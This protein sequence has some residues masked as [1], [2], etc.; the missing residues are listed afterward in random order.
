MS[1][2]ISDIVEIVSQQLG[3]F[4]I[5]ADGVSKF[6]AEDSEK[7]LGSPS[8]VHSVKY[9]IKDIEHLR[10]KISR[11]QAEGRLIS[12]ANVFQ[13]ITDI[14]GIRVLHLHLEQL[15]IIHAAILK[16]DWVLAETPK[17]Y[18][19]D[20]ETVTF[21]QSL[22]LDTH[23]KPSQYTSVHYVVKPNAASPLSCEIQV[24][25]LFEEIWGEVDHILNYPTPTTN[26]AS[27]EQLKVLAKVV[28]AG[29]RLVDSLFRTHTT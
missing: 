10:E 23:L 14:A 13:E 1:Q 6:F 27:A 3:E 9:R 24:R 16:R 7:L 28:G 5:Y 26:L 25:T 29:S 11:K 15:K 18:S 21:M 22:G 2:A 19:W 12:T 17:A 4:H 20:P 8:V